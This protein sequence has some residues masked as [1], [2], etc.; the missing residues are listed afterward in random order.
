[1][2]LLIVYVRVRRV[3]GTPAC[4]EPARRWRLACLL[5]QPVQLRSDGSRRICRRRAWWTC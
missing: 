5:R 1:L 4:T 3:K 2:P